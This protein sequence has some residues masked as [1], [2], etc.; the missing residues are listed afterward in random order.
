MAHH[1]HHRYH[2]G[3]RTNP[4]LIVLIVVLA[5]GLVGFL[6][7]DHIQEEKRAAELRVI[8]QQER[9][10]RRA[11]EEA[12]KAEEKRIAEERAQQ[13]AQ[14][15]FYQMLADG[16]DVNVLIV[17][18]SI[19]AGHGASDADHRWANLL[20]TNLKSKY[21]GEVKLTN[22]SMGGNTSYAGYVRTMALNDDINYDLVVLCYGQND[23]KNNFSLYYESIIR[24][25]KLRYPKASII[26]IQESSQKDYTEKMQT[27]K[28]IADHY[29]LPVADTIAP[30]QANYDNLVK[31]SVHPNDDGQQVYYETVMS[32]IEPLVTARQGYDPENVAVVNDQVTTF[33]TFQWFPVDQFKREGNTFILNTQ[34]HGSIL[35]IDYKFTSGA[36]SCKI[37]V[38]GVEYAAPEVTFNYDFSQR[39]IMIVNKWLE[40][41]TVNVQSEI[42]VVFG[43][44]EA[45]KNQ[46]DGF[47]GLAISGQ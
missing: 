10:E 18:D 43:E 46:A 8:E 7:Y 45:G 14:D 36:N 3:N 32:V 5:A 33:D 2:G 35:G 28:I 34:T 24:A 29:G 12:R 26:C 6:V 27:I 39:H 13:R 11:K 41:E 30:F 31:G 21:G 38:D 25:I 1:H 23:S 4:L 44:D 20:A 47:K 37:L 22:V 17:G 9:E 40:G 42:K 19:G 15:S 16:F